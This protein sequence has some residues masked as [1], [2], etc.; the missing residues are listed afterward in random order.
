MFAD[1]DRMDKAG[2]KKNKVVTLAIP[3]W[4]DCKTT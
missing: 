4:P 1:I 2:A 3:L